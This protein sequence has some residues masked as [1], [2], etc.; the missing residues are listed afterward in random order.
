MESSDKNRF[1]KQ[2]I[3]LEKTTSVAVNQFID[4]DVKWRKKEKL[5]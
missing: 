1:I 3:E 2:H 4:G 5:S